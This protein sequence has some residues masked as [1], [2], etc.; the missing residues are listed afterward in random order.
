M[1]IVGKILVFIVLIFS[2]LI[3]GLVVFLYAARV[4]YASLLKRETDFRKV[5]RAVADSYKNEK[6]ELI[7]DYDAQLAKMKAD[8]DRV[9]AHLLDQQTVN[10]T[11]QDS[12]VQEKK[13]TLDAEAL[14]DARKTEVERRQKEAEQ[15]LAALTAE[16]TKNFELLKEKNVLLQRTTAA[17][18]SARTTLE[19]NRRLEYQLQEMARDMARLRASGSATTVTK[20]DYNPP[21]EKIDGLIKA[22]DNSGLVKIT[23]GS[24]SGLLRGHTMEVFRINRNNPSQSKYLG[25]VRIIEVTPNEAV[26][27]PLG[28]MLDV[29]KPGDN[30]ASRIL[31]G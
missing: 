18:I 6:G 31:G 12:L 8:H 7:K 2:C 22:T 21:A 29:I 4:N 19:I 9:V 13:K 14:S 25:R 27:Q 24:D 23:L 11:L 28:R 16:R 15:N 17:E 26:A 10:R 30:V 20:P 5:D 3:L 1:T